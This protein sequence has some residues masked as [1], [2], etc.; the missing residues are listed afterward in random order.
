MSLKWKVSKDRTRV[1]YGK[2]KNGNPRDGFDY[3]LERGNFAE[4]VKKIR[5]QNPAHLEAFP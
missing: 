1:D 2:D 3:F 4:D 5:Q